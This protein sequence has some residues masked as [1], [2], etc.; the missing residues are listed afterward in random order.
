M[1]KFINCKPIHWLG[2]LILII[3]GCATLVEGST[4]TISVNSNVQGAEV[5]FNGQPIGVT[6]LTALVP[7]GKNATIVV[8]KEGYQAQTIAATTKITTA[9]WGN[10]ITGGLLGSTT[11]LVS[12]SAYE[13]AP[14]N[15]Y[16]NLFP[17]E[18]S[19]LQ[20]KKLEHKA[21]IRQFILFN[22]HSLIVDASRGQGEYLDALAHILLFKTK[23]QKQKL[24]KEILTIYGN[25]L[26]H[27]KTSN[28]PKFAEAI[29]TSSNN[30]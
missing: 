6:P 21:S 15:Y 24:A 4:Q 14:N 7:K 8:K 10:I 22:Y 20:L 16:A 5:L 17:I 18:S 25:T 23:E 13:Y 19:S 28:A 29:L 12:K 26:S 1:D 11:D 30:L 9:F 27:Q 3:S 2:I